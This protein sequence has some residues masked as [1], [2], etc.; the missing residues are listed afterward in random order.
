MFENKDV[1]QQVS[2]LNNALMNAL[3]F[4]SNKVITIAD[5]NPLGYQIP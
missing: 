4:V 2:N 1:N 5:R 3:N